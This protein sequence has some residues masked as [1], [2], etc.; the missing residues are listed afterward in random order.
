MRIE[1][2]GGAHATPIVREEGACDRDR[3]VVL[4]EAMKASKFGED[5]QEMIGNRGAGEIVDEPAKLCGRFH[6][7]HKANQVRL[8][9][10]VREE[11]TDNKVNRF[12]GVPA[13]NVSGDPADGTRRW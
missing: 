5:P 3:A 8:G 2:G 1:T 11:G 10:M 4:H 12:V 9:E 13:K 7:L 6:P